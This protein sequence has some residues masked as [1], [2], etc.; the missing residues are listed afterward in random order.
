MKLIYDDACPWCSR[1]NCKA[2]FAKIKNLS[3]QRSAVGEALAYQ[4]D[5]QSLNESISLLL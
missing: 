4:K 1:K 2:R 5:E 3:S